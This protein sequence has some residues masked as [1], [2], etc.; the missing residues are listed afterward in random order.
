MTSKFSEI[1]TMTVM[2]NLKSSNEWSKIYQ[3]R[4]NKVLALIE[5]FWID[6]GD[7]DGKE[8][9]TELLLNT[10]E[11][12][13]RDKQVCSW[14]IPLLDKDGKVVPD[15]WQTVGFTKPINNN[16][17]WRVS[18]KKDGM[19]RIHITA[20]VAEDLKS[21]HKDKRNLKVFE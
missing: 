9:V 3:E 16:G 4:H 11:I 1:T 6:D 15:K 7:A 8:S 10:C 18:A 21:Q 20:K 2:R 14:E 17:D 12:Q 5:K 19:P 13:H